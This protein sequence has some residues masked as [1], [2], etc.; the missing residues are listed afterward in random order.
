MGGLAGHINYLTDDIELTFAKMK[1]ILRAAAGGKLVGTEKVDGSNMYFGHNGQE[2]T[3]ARNKT[4]AKSGGMTMSGLQ[5][6]EFQGG[7]AVQTAF[8]EALRSF[9]ALVDSLGKEKSSIFGEEG[10]QN[11]F[12][13]EVISADSPNVVEYDDNYII[14]HDMGH[15]SVLEE[16]L[17]PMESAPLLALREAIGEGKVANGMKILPG[18]QL[19]IP[20]LDDNAP[21]K[22]ILAKIDGEAS[23]YG[24][25]DASSVGDYLYN[26]LMEQ[27]VGEISGLS[28]ELYDIV[29]QWYLKTKTLRAIPKET[30]PEIREKIRKVA[31]AQERSRRIRLATAPLEEATMEFAAKL[32]EKLSSALVSDNA[33]ATERLKSKVRTAIAAI[34]GYSGEHGDYVKDF[35]GRETAKLRNVDDI[36]SAFEGI[37]FEYD[38]RMYKF[39]GNFGP[40][41]Q[42]L[43]IMRYGRGPVPPL[44]EADGQENSVQEGKITTLI[45]GSFKPPSIAHMQMVRHYADYSDNVIIFVSPLPRNSKDRTISVDYDKSAAVWSIY[46]EAYGLLDKVSVLESPVNSPVAAAYQYI[47]NQEARPDW[48][49]AGDRVIVGVSAKDNDAARFSGDLQQYAM[50]GVKVYG[51]ED[52]SNELGVPP[53]AVVTV[54]GEPANSGDMREVLANGAINELEKYLPNEVKPMAQR[55]YDVLTDGEQKKETLREMIR[56]TVAR[57]LL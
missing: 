14:L 20:K 26:R 51:I 49:Q 24:L 35:L 41:N 32:L 46:L 21:L 50:E 7:E 55:I 9:S 29:V 53:V 37:V 5:A 56:N 25:T 1:K 10:A 11:F 18:L 6:H 12:N 42:I 16:V 40:I 34:Q 3:V 39:T 52:A 57:E 48:A 8:V 28:E 45:P 4:N 33:G 23:K 38:G 15:L 17:T 31:T 36:T 2:T 47:A 22:V 44:K 54:D 43:G 30:D 27:I 19:S 13:C